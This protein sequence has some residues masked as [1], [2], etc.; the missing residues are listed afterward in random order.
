MQH[1]AA[2]CSTYIEAATIGLSRAM[3]TPSQ[4]VVTAAAAVAHAASMKSQQSRAP[5]AVGLSCCPVRAG[6]TA[7]FVVLLA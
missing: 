2:C 1:G 5:P 4:I 6:T 7:C 3:V